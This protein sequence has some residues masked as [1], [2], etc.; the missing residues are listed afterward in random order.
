MYLVTLKS[1]LDVQQIHLR[2]EEKS[3]CVMA[4]LLVSTFD[5]TEKQEI[6]TER[7][8]RISTVHLLMLTN[9]DRLIFTMKIF[10]L[11]YK[12]RYLNE[13]VNCTEPSPSVSIPWEKI[14]LK[15]IVYIGNTG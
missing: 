4:P 3:C 2:W 15:W 13:E 5:E 6:L 10:H 11:C 7:A 12:T 9:L 14:Q 1:D 8:L